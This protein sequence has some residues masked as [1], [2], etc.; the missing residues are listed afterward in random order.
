LDLASIQFTNAGLYSVVVGNS[1][2]SVTN[3]P[4]Q[5]VVKDC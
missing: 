1:L 2:G 3:T 4:E 5:V